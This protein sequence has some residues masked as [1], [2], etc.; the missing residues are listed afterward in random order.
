M[1]IHDTDP[2]TSNKEFAPEGWHVPSD[3][4]WT[5]LEE[6]LTANG[7]NYDDATT[8]NTTT[9]NNIAKAMAS[10]TGWNISTAVGAPGND[11][12]LNNSSNFNA[13]AEGRRTNNG[14]YKDEGQDA[15]FWSSSSSGSNNVWIR[16]LSSNYSPLYRTNAYG[17]QNGFSVR[18]VRD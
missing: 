11:P 17:K 4:E 1:G 5:T 10:T 7:Y 6:F 2:N 3:A 13:F 14:P 18:F 16:Y 8:G 9:G 12:G 15:A